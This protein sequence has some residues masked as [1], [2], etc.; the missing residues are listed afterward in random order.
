MS[1]MAIRIIVA[2]VTISTTTVATTPPIM[3]VTVFPD[4][5]LNIA[6]SAASVVVIALVVGASVT[7][8]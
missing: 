6:E 1:A 2:A 3:M 4:F 8:V 7:V 5:E